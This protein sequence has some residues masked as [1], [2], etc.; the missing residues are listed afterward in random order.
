MDAKKQI[1]KI[2]DD[3]TG[4]GEL[5]CIADFIESWG[6]DADAATVKAVIEAKGF[7]PEPDSPDGRPYEDYLAH[8]IWYNNLP[9]KQ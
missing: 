2:L 9:L 6:I 8:C 3:N 5:H 1:K 7:S 4:S